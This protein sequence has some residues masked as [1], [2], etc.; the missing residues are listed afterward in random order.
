MIQRS[1]MLSVVG[2]LLCSLSC[3]P[4]RIVAEEEWR[5]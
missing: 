4:G 3:S 5:D 1:V 2:S